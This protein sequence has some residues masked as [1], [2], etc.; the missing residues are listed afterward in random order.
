MVP[1]IMTGNVIEATSKIQH[2]I[3]AAHCPTQ[4]TRGQ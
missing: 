1:V 2:K 4:E 3:N